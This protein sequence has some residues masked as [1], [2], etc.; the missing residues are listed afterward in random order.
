MEQPKNSDTKPQSNHHFCSSSQQHAASMELSRE[1]AITH[2]KTIIMVV[3]VVTA[4]ALSAVGIFISS[5]KPPATT[6]KPAESTETTTTKLRSLTEVMFVDPVKHDDITGG[7][8]RR[9]LDELLINERAQAAIN[10][11]DVENQR[12][13]GKVLWHLDEY[14]FLR[15]NP[16][17]IYPGSMFLVRRKDG[18]M[19]SCSTGWLARPSR[20]P[21]EVWMIT[22]GHCG[23][24]GDQVFYPTDNGDLIPAG[25]FEVSLAG[26]KLGELDYGLVNVTDAPGLSSRLPVPEGLQI[27]GWRSWEWLAENRPYT[28]R[29]G[30]RMG[31]SCGEFVGIEDI[32]Y[33]YQGIS[34]SGD[35]G[36]PV[37][38]QDPT[39]KKWYAIGTT[40]FI[41][42]SD[43]TN[44]GAVVIE[45]ILHP[46][47]LQILG[48]GQI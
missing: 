37:W 33:R 40:S 45:P 46:E 32:V 13:D 24:P 18:S 17:G 31:L 11:I 35:S 38:G 21:D 25:K 41:E 43:A 22:A 20:F 8:I 26:S 6:A 23:E 16:Q 3:V 48:A 29:I 30:A 42:E 44:A 39:T 28:C 14:D 34:N 4:L 47:G 2:Y 9:E 10:T 19:F 27:V 15:T 5:T 7:D 36:G 1:I 12:R